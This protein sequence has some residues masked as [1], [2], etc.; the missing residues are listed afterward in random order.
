MH[1]YVIALMAMAVFAFTAA[2]HAGVVAAHPGVSAV[3]FVKLSPDGTL[4]II[5]QH[6]ALAFALN[7]TPQNIADA[8]MYELLDGSENVQIHTFNE[9]RERFTS[10]F[11][12]K[13]DDHR[14]NPELIEFPTAAAIRAWRK[15]HSDRRLPLKLDIVL[16]AKLPTDA[17][18]I[19]LQFPSI[20]SDVIVSFDRPGRE[21]QAFP[22]PPGEPTPPLDVTLNRA[23]PTADRQDTGK[24]PAAMGT[25]A[26]AWRYIKLG[27]VHIVPDGPDHALFVLGLFLLTPKFKAVLWQIT[28]FTIAHTITLTLTALHIIGLPPTIVEPAIAASIAF[29]GIENLLATKINPW[30]YAVAFLF[31]LVHGMGIATAFT[32]AGFPPGQLV[33]SLAAFTV[34]VEAGH[35]AIL[36]AAFALLGWTRNRPW[37]RK[38][39]M[40]PASLLIAAVALVWFVMRIA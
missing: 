35:I 32:E 5:V 19:T 33:S 18:L 3:A 15:T 9:A 37:Y 2:T 26:I 21:P 29:I 39:V 11:E 17:R 34:G 22:V 24:P 27:F 16:Q 36:A 25:L 4:S 23:P 14:L 31:G 6:D 1:R 38:R 8:P 13:V 10:Q 40:I 28:A 12:L 20:L 30:R 7:E